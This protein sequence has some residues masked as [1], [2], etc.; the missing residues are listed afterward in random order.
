MQEYDDDEIG[1]LD[2]DDPSVL[3][4]APIEVRAPPP[5]PDPRAR[6]TRARWPPAARARRE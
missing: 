4:D 5:A 3:G 1:E 2:Q 6:P